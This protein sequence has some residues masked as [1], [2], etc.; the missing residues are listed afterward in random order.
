MR[1]VVFVWL[2]ILSSLLLFTIV[3]SFQDL[4]APYFSPTV[5]K[6][7]LLVATWTIGLISAGAVHL[8]YRRAER[9][10]E[11]A[12]RNDTVVQLA[13]GVAHELNQP[14]TMIISSGELL[15][16]HERSPEESRVLAGR[17]VEAALRMSGI[18]DKLQGASVYRSK[19]YVGNVR[20]VDLDQVG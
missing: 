5:L 8:M 6:V 11:Q 19:H 9:A 14:L 3:V 2:L 13:G 15:A 20:I 12:A 7:A 18:V 17:M 4:V 1:F 10:I 16:N